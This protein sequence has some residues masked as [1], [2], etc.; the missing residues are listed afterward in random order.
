MIARTRTVALFFVVAFSLASSSARA[1]ALLNEWG[2]TGSG[3][4]Q[5]RRPAGIAVDHGGHLLVVDQMNR[6][7][8]KLDASSGAFVAAIT[9]H[10]TTALPFGVAVDSSD[11]VYVVSDDAHVR[12]FASNGTLM[13]TWGT[14]GDGPGQFRKPSGIAVDAAD[15]VYVADRVNGTIQRFTAAGAHLST[16]TYAPWGWPIGIEGVAVDSSGKVYAADRRAGV[17]FSG[18]AIFDPEFES[19]L[20]S[21]MGLS[22]VAVAPG[23]GESVYVSEYW[24]SIIRKY[25]LAGDPVVRWFRAGSE[26][27]GRVGGIAVDPSGNV[28]ATDA[29]K[30]KIYKFSGTCGDTVCDVLENSGN[31]PIDCVDTCGNGY[32]SGEID[33]LYTLEACDDGPLNGTPGYCNATCDGWEG[34][35]WNGICDGAETLANF[36]ED[37]LDTD[38]DGVSD[39]MDAC[40]LPGS[41]PFPD[42]SVVSVFPSGV[43]VQASEDM[44]VSG[45]VRIGHEVSLLFTSET[46]VTA[47]S[48]DDTLGSLPSSA[49][50][51]SS[52]I[53]PVV[54][55]SIYPDQPIRLPGVVVC[56]KTDDLSVTH[57]EVNCGNLFLGLDAAGMGQYDLVMGNVC[58]DAGGGAFEVC[59]NTIDLSKMAL[60]YGEPISGVQYGTPSIIDDWTLASPSGDVTVEIPAG[61][62]ATQAG[63]QASP[64]PGN[65][66]IDVNGTSVP[67]LLSYNLLPHGMTFNTPV[68]VTINVGQDPTGLDVFYSA[69]GN[70]PWYA[71]S[72]PLSGIVPGSIVRD[73]GAQ[74]V[75]FQTMHFSRYAFGGTG[76][77][78]Q[79]VYC[80]PD[81]A[82]F[83][84]WAFED[85]WPEGGDYDMND[86]VMS[87][88]V[89]YSGT[90]SGMT[91]MEL[92]ARA[93]ARGS[94]SVHSGFAVE[95]PVPVGN[96]ASQELTRDVGTG[97]C[98]AEAGYAVESS[99]AGD[100]ATF[101]LFNDSASVL[102]SSTCAFYNTR[103]DCGEGEGREFYLK[104]TFASP[105][106]IAV[107]DEG[108][109]PFIFRKGVRG[110]EVHLPGYPPTVEG[111]ENLF[112][113]CAPGTPVCDATNLSAVEES[114]RNYYMSSGHLPWALDIPGEWVW[115]QEKIALLNV[116]PDFA[117]WAESGGTAKKDW[118]V[119][120]AGMTGPNTGLEWTNSSSGHTVTM[121]ASCSP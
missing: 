33:P 80:Y 61:A 86:L 9:G 39:F 5:F 34:F 2:G 70:P 65:V 17:V 7:V 35:G 21:T 51:S 90:S 60:L 36:P 12:K 68:T 75:S 46:F 45:R 74:T 56:L 105:V 32:N 44:S 4:G 22:I 1:Q 76:A 72:D 24:S 108:P 43:I 94:G 10:W 116:Y 78:G 18:G 73:V 29:E 31:C 99:N 101:I 6:R 41:C 3:N 11:N 19:D 53:G 117:D 20:M 104:V 87:Y 112:A 77:G 63:I 49:F 79:E 59:G 27:I 8:Q 115:P 120:G 48:I 95:L 83:G 97:S 119:D 118:F 71:A 13:T 15:V 102:P 64:G 40:P 110:H 28:Y 62:P 54:A 42:D 55:F 93:V 98:L 50:Y 47:Q 23:A 57:P 38:S 37:C 67:T 82:T 114:E 52:V 109:S 85:L 100:K 89:K 111:D 30:N 88:R 81:C 96:I 107:L 25:S 92:V 91:E 121:A 14:L 66:A 106:D 58:N 103:N 113:S 69:D 84:T 16:I 26:M